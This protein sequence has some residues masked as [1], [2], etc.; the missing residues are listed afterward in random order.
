MLC[1]IGALSLVPAADAQTTQA[2]LDA[3]STITFRATL[4]GSY[5][6]WMNIAAAAS[7]EL[8]VAA[9]NSS[10]IVKS[11][12]IASPPISCTVSMG[13]DVGMT[14]NGL[15]VDTLASAPA[16]LPAQLD[17][18]NL[19]FSGANLASAAAGTVNYSATGLPCTTLH[20]HGG[21]C[22]GPFN[23][24]LTGATTT[25]QILSGA[26]SSTPGPSGGRDF[27]ISYFASFPL[28]T[29]ATWGSIAVSAQLHGTFPES[30]AVACPAD[31]DGVN[32]LSVVDIFQFLNAWFAGDQRANFNHNGGLDVQDI[33]DFLN[34]WFVGC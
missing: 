31:F 14:V 29:G 23:L 9:D 13:G 6:Q 15:I 30:S 11:I 21:Q 7:L 1:A 24:A 25:G 17:S 16:T 10:V 2:V 8:G 20:N 3:S 27:S 22:S 28:T 33:F 5:T 12:H 4:A 19:V 32:G 26:V 34:A 18:G